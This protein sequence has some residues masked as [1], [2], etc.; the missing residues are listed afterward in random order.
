SGSYGIQRGG[1]QIRQAAATAR[2]GLV[3]L[4]AK[5]LNVSPS[6]LTIA[7]GVVRPASGGPGL[8][9]AELLQGKQFDLKL[10][11]KAPRKNPASY[12]LVGKPLPRPDVPGKCDGSHAYMH[13]FVLPG[14]L[15]ARM[16]RPSSPNAQLTAVDESSISAIPG[17]RVVRVKDFLAVVANDE[18]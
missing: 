13:N 11:P 2:K 4:A 16:I 1:M 8:T 10:D 5:R 14:M 7:D 15:H 18:W 9:F 12:K 3:E 6:D 17:A